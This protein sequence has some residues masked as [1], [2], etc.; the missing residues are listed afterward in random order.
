MTFVELQSFSKRVYD[1]L[2]D[3]SLAALEIEL[4]NARRLV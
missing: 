3:A 2:D 4:I 1:L